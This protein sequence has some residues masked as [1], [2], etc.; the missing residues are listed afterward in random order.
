MEVNKLNVVRNTF[1][2]MILDLYNRRQMSVK[3]LQKKVSQL[4]KCRLNLGTSLHDK[5]DKTA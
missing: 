5:G 4:Q 2:R 3:A 1:R